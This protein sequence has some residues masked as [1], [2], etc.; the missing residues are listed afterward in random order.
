MDIPARSPRDRATAVLAALEALPQQ[1]RLF[2]TISEQ[3]KRQAAAY[4]PQ[5]SAL[6][7]LC[8]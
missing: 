8:K 5:R 7:S 1:T 3:Q 2:A 6:R 4:D